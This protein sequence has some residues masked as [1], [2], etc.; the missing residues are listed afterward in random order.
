VVALG[1]W[2]VVVAS[3]VLVGMRGACTMLSEGELVYE[4]VCG[5]QCVWLKYDSS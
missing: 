1:L 4:A 3:G 2:W 5:V